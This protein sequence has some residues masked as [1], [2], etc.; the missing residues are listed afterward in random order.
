MKSGYSG[1]GLLGFIGFG[2]ELEEGMKINVIG[3]I[4]SA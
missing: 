2:F 1:D 3:R 4:Q